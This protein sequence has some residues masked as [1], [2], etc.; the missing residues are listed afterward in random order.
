MYKDV[1]VSRETTSE[2]TTMLYPGY[3]MVVTIR[4]ALSVL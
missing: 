4:Y 2:A 1:Q 3:I